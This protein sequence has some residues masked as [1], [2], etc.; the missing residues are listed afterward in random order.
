MASN[1]DYSL[2][3]LKGIGCFM[4]MIAH[5]PVAN[6]Y[7]P[8]SV[9]NPNRCDPTAIFISD[10]GSLGMLYFFA[11]AGVTA[12]IQISKY[13]AL[14]LLKFFSLLGVV[15]FCYTAMIHPTLYMSPRFEV[16]QIIALGSIAVVLLETYVKPGIK[17]YFVLAL[18]VYGIKYFFDQRLPNIDGGGVLFP[19][20]DYVPWAFL[21]NSEIGVNPGFPIFPW[22]SYFFA[23]YAAYFM[24]NKWN[25][26][27]AILFFVLALYFYIFQHS[28]GLY[29]DKFDMT[30]GYFA[31]SFSVLFISFYMGRRWFTQAP[32]NSDNILLFFG[33]NSLMVFYVHS[34]GL[35]AG[36]LLFRFNQYLAWLV[37]FVVTYGALKLFSKIKPA[38]IFENMRSWYVLALLVLMVP[39]I[40]F[41]SQGAQTIVFFLEIVFG[42]IFVINFPLVA[43][44]LKKN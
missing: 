16:F 3:Y 40:A 31:I 23:G 35:M 4:M 33:Q 21:K 38:K 11:V 27:W 7:C 1:R 26:F 32:N 30:P 6:H 19:H 43:Q 5:L 15:G 18:L 24:Q 41:Q 42:Y 34:F 29:Y 37:V 28:A 14:S 13:N 8:A 20:R 10:V 36:S 44:L 12:A 22:L 17:G 2:D 39:L 9:D 25:I